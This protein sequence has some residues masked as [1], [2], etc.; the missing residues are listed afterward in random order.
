M[1]L[2]DEIR[3]PRFQSEYQKLA[4]NL[5]YTHARFEAMYKQ[6]LK[7]FD[8]T[9]EQYN[10]LR[11][12]KG[13]HPRPMGVKDIQERMLTPTSNTSRLIDKL[14][15]KRYVERAE[16]EHDRRAVDVTLTPRGL[17][18]LRALTAEVERVHE[19]YQT[20]STAEAQLLNSLLDKLRG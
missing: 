15:Q 6:A 11:I 2:E 4:V 1:R 5:L 8:I 3:Q 16:C 19:R 13:S 14:K 20:L 10:V 17:E 12:L 18:R 7:P 9:P